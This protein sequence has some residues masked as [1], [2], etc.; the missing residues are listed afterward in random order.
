MS[1]PAVKDWL[2]F[3][4]KTRSG[5]SCQF[6]CGKAKS[7][8]YKILSIGKPR[9]GRDPIPIDFVPFE[10]SNACINGPSFDTLGEAERFA[11]SL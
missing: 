9:L 7:G 1:E 6:Y 5:I 8:R 4:Y 10:I 3:R 11:R 2:R